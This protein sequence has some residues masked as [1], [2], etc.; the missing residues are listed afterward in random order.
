MVRASFG[1]TLV[2]INWREGGE[3]E[4]KDSKLSVIDKSS[5]S[6]FPIYRPI[7]PL[8]LSIFAMVSFRWE[9]MREYAKWRESE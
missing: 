3:G 5:L 9:R 1:L 7:S 2:G 4:S 8:F 6:L